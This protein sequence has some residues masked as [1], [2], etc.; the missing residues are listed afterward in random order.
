MSRRI[1]DIDSRLNLAFELDKE[2]Y[3]SFISPAL[4][5]L[6][7]Y[8]EEE[9]LGKSIF[10]FSPIA[11]RS[12]LQKHL[13][14]LSRHQQAFE[15]S[16]LSKHGK[17]IQLISR[18]RQEGN[19]IRAVSYDW[20]EQKRLED[21]LF[22]LGRALQPYEQ[23][24]SAEEYFR[25]LVANISQT[26]SVDYAFLTELVD[27]SHVR[28]LAFWNGNDFGKPF[29]YRLAETPCDDVIN[30]NRICNYPLN[31]QQHFPH[32]RDLVSLKAEGYVGVP[33]TNFSGKVV[34]HI[35][36]LD[37]KPLFLNE[38]YSNI[39]RAFAVRCGAMMESMMRMAS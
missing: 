36:V 22:I 34:G 32:D 11:Q 33:V 21:A 30:T 15:H 14:K 13:E 29:M 7:A 5:N 16:L 24:I 18:F 2:A 8:K 6:L 26:L 35:A 1:I 10:D 37:R 19:Q 20:T 3:M 25:P 31:V 39:L 38:V 12:L 23:S 17:L 4:A 27:G 9:L 28:M